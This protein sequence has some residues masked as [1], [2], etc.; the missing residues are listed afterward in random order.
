M[1]KIL[2]VGR[3]FTNEMMEAGAVF[4]SE[5]E[6]SSLHLHAAL[7][8]Q[9]TPDDFWKFVLAFPEVRLEGPRAVYKKLR[10]I[11]NRIPQNEFRIGTEIVSVVEERD[12]LIQIFKG[13]IRVDGG[14]VRFARNSLN[15]TYIEDAYI[16]KMV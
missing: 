15:G 3:S 7:W 12:R 4:V 9:P 11:S 2:L 6:K 14:G 5:I 13:V 10:S 16:Y 8:I 1:D